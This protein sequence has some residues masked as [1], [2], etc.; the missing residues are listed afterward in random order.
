[1]KAIL[2]NVVKLKIQVLVFSLLPSILGQSTSGDKQDFVF[3]I[4]VDII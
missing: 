2:L 3:N 4:D 1:M